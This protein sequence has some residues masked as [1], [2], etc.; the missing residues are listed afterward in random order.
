MTLPWDNLVGT[1]DIQAKFFGDIQV[2]VVTISAF[3]GWPY[4]FNIAIAFL[5][6]F[7]QKIPMLAYIHEIYKRH[8]E[9]PSERS[10]G[11]TVISRSTTPPTS[12]DNPSTTPY[13]D[14]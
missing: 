7:I 5:T 2:L 11:G 13:Q 6:K 14:S 3:V 12:E 1:V 4:H 9:T 8:L 10:E